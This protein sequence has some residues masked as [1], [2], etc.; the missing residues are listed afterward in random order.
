[1][2][3]ERRTGAAVEADVGAAGGV[4]EETGGWALSG[5]LEAVVGWVP[6]RVQQL[7]ERQGEQLTAIA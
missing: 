2:T 3:V 5:G 7:I 4:R 6:E 1:M